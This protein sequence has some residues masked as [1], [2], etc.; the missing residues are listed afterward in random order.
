MKNDI[1]KHVFSAGY[2]STVPAWH[3]KEAND[4]VLH[5]GVVYSERLYVDDNDLPYRVYVLTADPTKV[6]FYTGSNADGYKFSFE[7]HERENVMQHIMAAESNNVKVIGGTNANHF[8]INGDHH[9]AG[10][11]VKEGKLIANGTARPYFAI[12]NEGKLVFGE[13]GTDVD[14]NTL[15]TAVSGAFYIVHDSL[16]QNLKMDE[17]IG[18]TPHP[19]TLVGIKA[20]STVVMAVIDGRREHLSN[21]ASLAKCAAFMIAEGAVQAITLDGGGSST[22]I[23][24]EG[25]SFVTKNSPCDGELRK[26]PLSLLIIKKL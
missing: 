9:P 22:F 8:D 6:D 25:D 20:D 4:R 21:G 3:L 14:P 1:A 18:Y 12:T 11:A 10:L 23:I 5:D 19:R 24:K 15:H 16:P 7:P 2:E 17:D 13:H 26:L